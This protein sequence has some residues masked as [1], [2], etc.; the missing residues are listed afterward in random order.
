MNH[1]VKPQYRL[2]QRSNGKF[3]A[4]H[5]LTGRQQSLKT[6]DQATAELLLTGLNEGTR[7]AQVSREVGLA[8]QSCSDPDAKKRTWAWVFE[9]VLKTKSQD[10][11]NYRRWT[12]ALKDR[13]FASIR[14]LPL[15]DTRAEH[16]LKILH[17]G[18]VST[19]VFLR[20][21]H[22]F[23]VDMAWLARPVIVKRQWPKV[24]HKKKRAITR[25]LIQ[26]IGPFKMRTWH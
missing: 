18:T 7:D 13:A 16:F 1:D 20:R 26:Q 6:R 3:Y 8:Y 24:K 11:D 21:I 23:A 17:E 19:N 2:Y 12:V 25:E 15:I 14:T 4:Q 5:C 10:T 9:E 22:S